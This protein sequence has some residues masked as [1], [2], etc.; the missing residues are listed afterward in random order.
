MDQLKEKLELGELVRSERMA[1]K[2]AEEKGKRQTST[3]S[4]NPE[5][6]RFQISFSEK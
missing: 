1:N 4:S 3:V 6:D 5:M 2:R